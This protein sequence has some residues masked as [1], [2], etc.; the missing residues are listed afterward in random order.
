MFMYLNKSS[1]RS[2][3]FLHQD[4]LLLQRPS[5][6][7]SPHRPYSPSSTAVEP[8]QTVTEKEAYPPTIRLEN[9]TEVKPIGTIQI[10]KESGTVGLV[11]ID[12]EDTIKLSRSRFQLV[13]KFFHLYRSRY[14]NSVVVQELRIRDS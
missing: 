11:S 12:D 10:D 5:P 7:P 13:G 14:A 6:P 8:P 3:S 2:S 4:E 1:A 9:D